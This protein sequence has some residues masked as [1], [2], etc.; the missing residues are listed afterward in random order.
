[1]AY[2][3]LK[4]EGEISQ[5]D[6]KVKKMADGD[7]KLVRRK[8]IR[9]DELL[10]NGCGSCIIA[11][12]EGAIKLADGKARVVSDA[13]CDG[14]GA[15]IGECPTGAL[16]I[17]VREAKAFDEEA[18]RA[19][20]SQSK[21]HQEESAKDK[22]STIQSMPISP[23][24]AAFHKA[25]GEGPQPHIRQLDESSQLCSWPIQMR[26]AHTD[27]PYF[28]DARLLIAADCSAFASTSISEFIKGR[29]VLIGC[30]KLDESPPFLE[31]LIE[32]L[33]CNDIREIT[34]LHMEVPCCSNLVW[35]VSQAIKES[36]KDIPLQK[37]ICMINGSTAKE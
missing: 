28:K 9:I 11:C 14:L 20:L 17:E 12:S 21:S 29:V 31:K 5:C 32:I 4:D 15:C 33:R 7:G 23:C 3:P 1:M 22:T 37:F 13:F 16:T 34:V 18:A 27:A 2:L 35:L 26:L 36:G 30:P 19:N 10:C 6:F 24:N 25:S 8:I